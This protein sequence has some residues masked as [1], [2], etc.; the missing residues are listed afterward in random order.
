MFGRTG[1]SSLFEAFFRDNLLSSDP[2]GSHD[3]GRPFNSDRQPRVFLHEYH[4]G[5]EDLAA[6]FKSTYRCNLDPAVPMIAKRE[7]LTRCTT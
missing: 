6:F 2:F 5:M 3:F 4:P 1:N 7:L